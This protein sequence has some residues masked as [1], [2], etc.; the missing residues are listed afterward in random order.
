VRESASKAI[1][2]SASS[3]S[4]RSWSCASPADG[5][6]LIAGRRLMHPLLHPLVRH[7]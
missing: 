4:P 7:L 1:R 3:Q 2:G 5:A 6:L